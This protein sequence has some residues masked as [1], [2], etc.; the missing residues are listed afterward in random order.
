MVPQYNSHIFLLRVSSSYWPTNQQK[1]NQY[2]IIYY[3]LN[4]KC[5]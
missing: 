1:Y 2:N 3:I 4:V 5:E